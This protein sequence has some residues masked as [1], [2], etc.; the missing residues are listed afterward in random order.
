M[1]HV[2]YARHYWDTEDYGTFANTWTLYR[3]VE[4]SQIGF[5]Q[6]KCA[7]LKEQADKDYADY[8]KMYQKALEKKIA[9]FYE[10]LMWSLPMDK[11]STIEK[12]F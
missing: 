11:S 8:E 6:G 1:F 9:M 10:S 3:N 4:Y 5:M 12:F 7:E 2:V